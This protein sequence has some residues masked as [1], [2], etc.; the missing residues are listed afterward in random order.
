MQVSLFGLLLL[1]QPLHS[2]EQ[3]TRV[4]LEFSSNFDKHIGDGMVMHG[5]CVDISYF[6]HL[7]IFQTVYM[8]SPLSPENKFAAAYTNNNQTILLNTLVSE[9]TIIDCPFGEDEFVGKEFCN[10]GCGLSAA[11]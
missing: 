8:N 11:I 2:S 6:H 5:R 4:N 3:H 10:R 7:K 1:T 9:F